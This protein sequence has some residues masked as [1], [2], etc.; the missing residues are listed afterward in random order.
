MKGELIKVMTQGDIKVIKQICIQY[1]IG[2]YSK[3]QNN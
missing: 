3:H 2:I 1:N